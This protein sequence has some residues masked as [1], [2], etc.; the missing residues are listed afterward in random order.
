MAKDPSTDEGEQSLKEIAEAA[1][2]ERQQRELSAETAARP[3]AKGERYIQP[4]PR[5]ANAAE[6]TQKQ[7]APQKP[8]SDAS[9]SAGSTKGRQSLGFVAGLVVASGVAFLLTRPKTPEP[10][11]ER[12]QTEV[13]A[14]PSPTP[15]T[16]EAVAEPSSAENAEPSESG[17]NPNAPRPL[18]LDSLP[19]DPGRDDAL[20]DERRAAKAALGNEATAPPAPSPSPASPKSGSDPETNSEASIPAPAKVPAPSPAAASEPSGGMPDRPSVGAVQAAIGATLGRARRCLAGQLQPSRALLT[21]GSDGTVQSVSITGP[22]AG[23]PAEACAKA[24]LSRAR[25]APFANPTFSVNTTL[26][27]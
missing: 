25:V 18:S 24:A 17:S 7:T 1:V 14:P 15:Q 2:E 9:P 26:R 13:V 8:S 11:A 6:E 3:S 16:S 5:R 21:F 27:P 23:T 19:E 12:I 22:A 10:E 20:V 4:A